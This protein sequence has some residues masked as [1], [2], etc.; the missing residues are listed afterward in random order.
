[1]SDERSFAIRAI[2][3]VRLPL[4]ALLSLLVRNLGASFGAHP[5]MMPLRIVG[6]LA[7]AICACLLHIRKLVCKQ[8]IPSKNGEVRAA[9]LALCLL[10]GQSSVEA[11]SRLVFECT[12]FLAA[13]P[14]AILGAVVPSLKRLSTERAGH[15][16]DIL[17]IPTFAG[18]NYLRGRRTSH[19][20]DD[21]S[22]PILK[23]PTCWDEMPFASAMK[24]TSATGT[25]CA[26]PGYR[27]L[28][29]AE[30]Q[31]AR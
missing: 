1:M 17:A 20:S 13:F 19:G 26:S 4:S 2:A 21:R 8:F 24:G 14:R 6:E 12:A 10:A 28:P 15:H 27:A 30:T 5:L 22:H 29:P 31:T 16:A 11:F 3:G 25:N 23:G 9:G 7:P 18:K